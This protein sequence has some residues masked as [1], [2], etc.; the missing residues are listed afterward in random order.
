MTSSSLLTPF[1]LPAS[2]VMLP[3]LRKGVVEVVESSRR[4]DVWWAVV[5]DRRRFAYWVG[6]GRLVVGEVGD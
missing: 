6:E 3:D 4:R 5:E 2:D 1:V